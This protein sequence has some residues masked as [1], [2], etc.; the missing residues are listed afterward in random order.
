MR[1]ALVA[2][3]LCLTTGAATAQ[4]VH[5]W[6]CGGG[7]AC[8]EIVPGGAPNQHDPTGDADFDRAMAICDLH[9]QGN[10]VATYPPYI[11]HDYW[12]PYAACRKIEEAWSRFPYAAREK[13]RLAKDK[14]DLDFLNEYVGKLP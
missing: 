3:L 8:S 10:L 2:I 4:L 1:A 6:E 13:A 5:S 7:V 11:S 12:K 14:S 9:Q